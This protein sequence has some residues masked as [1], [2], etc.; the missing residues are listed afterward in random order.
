[1]GIQTQI[2][3]ISST[4]SE[5]AALLDQALAAIQNKSAGAGAGGDSSD[6]DLQP[7]TVTPTEEA[8]TFTPNGFDGY[9]TVSVNAINKTYIGSGVA[10]Q[11]AQIIIPGTSDKTI[12]SGR[13]LDGTQII[14]GDTNLLAENI[15]SGVSIFSVIGT[16]GDGEIESGG[17]PTG[18]SKLASG[19]IT[20]TSDVASLQTIT[21]GL[22]VKPDLIA[23]Y[24]D[25]GDTVV[26]SEHKAYLLKQTS[27]ATKYNHNSTTYSYLSELSYVATDTK[28]RV[29][30]INPGSTMINDSYFRVLC[31]SSYVLKTGVTYRW[32]ACVFE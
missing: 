28:L 18:I 30:Q 8:R 21:H 11:S 23:V 10:R 20:P 2:D 19:S 22:G 27:V 12:D 15:K 16:F 24:A 14:K 26:G 7:L 29:T 31:T 5:Q 6:L 25:L 4:I 3:R 1:M 17:L 32:I 13:Y 9:S